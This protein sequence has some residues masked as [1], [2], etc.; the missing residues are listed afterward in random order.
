[1]HSVGWVD[2]SGFRHVKIQPSSEAPSPE[3]LEE[4]VDEN[5][6]IR[7]QRPSQSGLKRFSLSAILFHLVRSMVRLVK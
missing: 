4:Q 7:Q 5:L 2:S 6:L 3:S 1:M